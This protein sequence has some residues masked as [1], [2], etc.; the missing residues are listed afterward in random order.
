MLSGFT[1]FL[2]EQC[3]EITYDG[4]LPNPQHF[5]IAS[6]ELHSVCTYNSF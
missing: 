3:L 5:V 1:K 6:L 2:Q 4:F